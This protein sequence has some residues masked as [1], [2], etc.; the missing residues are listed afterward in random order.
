M[1]AVGYAVVEAIARPEFLQGVRDNGAF[2]EAQLLALSRE[3]KLGPVRGAGLLFALEL[4]RDVG[5]QI[6]DGALARQL[7]IN[8]PRPEVLRFMPALNVSPSEI[9]E[10]VEILREVILSV[11]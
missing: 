7:L 5:P 1:T 4:G 11:R 3:Q 6:V 2:L 9:G 8:A 10:M